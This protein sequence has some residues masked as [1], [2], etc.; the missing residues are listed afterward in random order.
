MERNQLMEVVD[1]VMDALLS[2]PR[3]KD[4]IIDVGSDRGIVIL[5]GQ[6]NKVDI[7]EAAEEIARKQEGVITVINEIKVG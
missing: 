1:R 5:K 2:D 4:A 6:V 7:R 3:T